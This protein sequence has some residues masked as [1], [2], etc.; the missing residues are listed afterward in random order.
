MFFNG[1]FALHGSYNVPGYNDSHGC[2]RLF[3]NDAQ[4]LNQEFTDGERTKVIV[5]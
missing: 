1:N 4:W 3:V 5:Q 2:V